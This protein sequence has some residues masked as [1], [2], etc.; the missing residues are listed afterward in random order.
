MVGFTLSADGTTWN[1]G[2]VDGPEGPVLTQLQ[3]AWL[4]H[5]EY[6]YCDE[7][8]KFRGRK[9][10]VTSVDLRK[11]VAEVK[12]L[13]PVSTWWPQKTWHSFGKLLILLLLLLFFFFICLSPV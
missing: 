11:Q 10:K 5:V 4:R 12:L 3:A 7:D 9:Y 1:S 13:C 2:E 6:S 8:L